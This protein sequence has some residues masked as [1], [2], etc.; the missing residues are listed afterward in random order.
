[1]KESAGENCVDKCIDLFSNK[2]K[3][4]TK[5]EDMQVAHRLGKREERSGDRQQRARPRAVIVQ[6]ASRRIRDQI[7][8]N[9]KVL[10]GTGVA[11]AEDL[12]TAN[13]RLLQKAQE[14]AATKTAWP[15]NGK[16]IVQL[17]NG[18]KVRVEVDTDMD[19]FFASHTKG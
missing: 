8:S 19:R 2:I 18:K 1:M 9:R 6:F 3:I 15:S 17:K 11:I 4:K 16:I 7:I 14:H 13:F 10:V 5:H 12:T